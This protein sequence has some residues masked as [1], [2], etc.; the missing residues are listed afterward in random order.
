M[1]VAQ[2]LACKTI[3]ELWFPS[4]SSSKSDRSLANDATHEAFNARVSV[5]LGVVAKFPDRQS[6]LEDLLHQVQVFLHKI[7]KDIDLILV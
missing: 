4:E 6:P 1:T 3:G 2:D 5:I 7:P